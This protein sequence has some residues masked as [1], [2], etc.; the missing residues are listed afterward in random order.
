MSARIQNVTINMD[1]RA[2][3]ETMPTELYIEDPLIDFSRFREYKISDISVYIPYCWNIESAVFSA[4]SLNLSNN[5]PGIERE[6]RNLTVSLGTDETIAIG[7]PITYSTASE[8]SKYYVAVKIEC[9]GGDYEIP[10]KV[11]IVDNVCI[12]H[13]RGRA[14]Y[15]DSVRLTNA[16]IQGTALFSNTVADITS[17]S[18][19]FPGYAL[20]LLD[21]SQIQIE[22]L[23]VN[24][25]NETYPYSSDPA[26]SANFSYGSNIFVNS[27][28][29]SLM[30]TA[31]LSASEDYLACTCNNEA[32]GGHFIHRSPIGIADTWNVY[33]TDGAPA[34]IK[35]ACPS[36]GGAMVLG[37]KPFHGILLTPSSAGRQILKAYVAYKGFQ[38]DELGQNMIVSVSVQ[39]AEGV[40]ETYWSNVHG[41]WSDD[42]ESVW[43]NDTGLTQKCL[44]IPMDLTSINPL[45]I[46]VFYSWKHAS[47][48]VY[49][50]PAIKLI[51]TAEV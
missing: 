19:W 24:L 44:E 7:S 28:N 50:D 4:V 46:R 21:C 17:L 13:P 38:T 48:F 33:R 27:S 40:T 47:G 18:T 45:D 14:I 22:T 20:I 23:T 6:I 9:Y 43:N 11:P 41:R 8:S 5:V 12:D 49:L 34:C 26:V 31:T 51:Q 35:L 15:C 30:A 2:L 29:V 25:E 37:R 42:S 39:N 36:A 3:N 32:A 10:A 1:G 16:T